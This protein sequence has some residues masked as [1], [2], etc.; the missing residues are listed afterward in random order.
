MFPTTLTRVGIILKYKKYCRGRQHRCSE[1]HCTQ[2]VD[3]LRM[4]NKRPLPSQPCQSPQPN[5]TST[6]RRLRRVRLFSTLSRESLFFHQM[7]KHSLPNEPSA[8]SEGRRR[9]AH[10]GL[11]IPKKIDM[12]FL[13]FD[14]DRNLNNQYTFSQVAMAIQLVLSVAGTILTHPRSAASH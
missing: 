14:V 4:A 3:R 12:F 11:V 13:L 6:T 1:M 5:R 2:H 7:L 9:V 8:T 10:P